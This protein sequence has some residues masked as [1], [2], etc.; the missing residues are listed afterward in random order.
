MVEPSN[1]PPDEEPQK[2][3]LDPGENE[4][5]ARVLNPLSAA[6]PDGLSQE[7]I[8]FDAMARKTT[9]AI[10]GGHQFEIYR[11]SI[12]EE[13]IPVKSESNYGSRAPA[14]KHHS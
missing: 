11:P 10:G 5:D 2:L 14:S 6:S 3:P 4:N 1:L 12:T 9:E 13:P 8:T 7:L